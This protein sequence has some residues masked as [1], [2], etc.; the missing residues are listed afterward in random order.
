ML[1]S[2]PAAPLLP[3]RPRVSNFN[4]PGNG[5]QE[6]TPLWPRIPYGEMS[7]PRI[8]RNGWLYVDKT[9]YLHPL[10]DERHVFF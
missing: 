3:V 6:V 8:R 1:C 2:L 9:R 4:V 5:L 10:E 7:F